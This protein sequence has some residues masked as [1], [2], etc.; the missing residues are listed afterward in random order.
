[1]LS[2]LLSTVTGKKNPKSIKKKGGEIIKATCYIKHDYQDTLR[3]FIL[4]IHL[5]KQYRFFQYIVT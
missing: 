2:R 3:V 1:M 4:I 5:H